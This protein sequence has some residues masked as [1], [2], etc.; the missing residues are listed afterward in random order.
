MFKNNDLLK[1]LSKQVKLNLSQLIY[2]KNI[3]IGVVN[4]SLLKNLK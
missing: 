1:L 4:L 3:A 2:I